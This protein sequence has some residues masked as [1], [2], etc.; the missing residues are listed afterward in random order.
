M[1]REIKLGYEVR[2]IMTGFQGIAVGRTDW[3]YS[4]SRIA[5]RTPELVRGKPV[6]DQWFDVQQLDI[7]KESDPPMSVDSVATKPGGNKVPVMRGE[8]G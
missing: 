4:C 3:L 5:V 8:S 7:V 1:G 6:D 2:D